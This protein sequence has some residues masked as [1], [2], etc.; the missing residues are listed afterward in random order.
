MSEYRRAWIAGA[1]YFLTIVTH[2]HRPI[3]TGRGVANWRRALAIV[4]RE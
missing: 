3:L 2:Q 4:R 1:T